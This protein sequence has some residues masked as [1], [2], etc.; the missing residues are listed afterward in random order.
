MLRFII[1]FLLISNTNLAQEQA[2]YKAVCIGFYNLENLFDTI[3]DL[4]KNDHEFLPAG[5]KKWTSARYHEKLGN[6]AKVIGSIGEKLGVDAPLALGI[7]EIENKQVVADLI[8]TP[9]LKDKNYGIVHYNSPDRR[10]VDVGF[11]YRKEFFKVIASNSHRVVAPDIPNFITRDQLVVTG[12]I[13]TDTL[14]FIV[15]H[16]PSRSGGQKRSEPRRFKAAELTRHIVDSLQT[17]NP[18]AKILIMGD[19][20]DDPSNKSVRK[21]LG[22]ETDTKNLAP[23]ALFNPMYDMHRK[24]LGTLAYRDTWQIFDQ[25]ILSQA[26]VQAQEVNY[27]YMPNSAS[28]FSPSW[29]KQSEGRYAGYPLRTY[30]GPN[31]Q[32]GYSDHFPVYLFL[33]KKNS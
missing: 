19:L 15:N 20:N 27:F 30:V 9:P 2:S 31:Y 24:G 3:Q 1:L 26:L 14:S 5:S 18:E 33:I 10:G 16:W 11:I 23:K 29:I 32:A 7:C 25:I 17:I 13:E 6:M 8:N 12:V 22:T 21:V 4:N 28:V